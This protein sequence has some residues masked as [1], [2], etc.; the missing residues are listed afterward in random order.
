MCFL[1]PIPVDRRPRR[2]AGM[3]LGMLGLGIG[4][5]L[6]YTPYS[7]LAKSLAA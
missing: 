2:F 4:Y 1:A 6:W 5:F 3:S 7:G